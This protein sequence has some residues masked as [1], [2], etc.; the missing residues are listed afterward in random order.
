M[1]TEFNEIFKGIQ[2]AVSFLSK[3]EK[4]SLIAA[5]FIMLVTGFLTNLPAVILGK[6][7]DRVVS[8]NTIPFSIVI[9]YI[10]SIII[11]ILIREALTVIRKYLVEN[12]ATQTDKDISLQVIERLLK[13]DIQGFL[14]KQQIGSLH[15]RIFRSMQGLVKIIKLTFLDF[16]PI[17]F[18]AIAAIFIALYQ[19]PII[20]TVMILV[21]PMGLFLIIKQISSQKGIRISLLRGKEK[22]DGKVVEMLGGIETIRVLDTVAS[23]IK[24]I[25]TIAEDQRKIEIRHHIYMALFDAAKYLNEGFFYIIVILLSVYLASKGII[26]KGDILVYSILFVSITAPL[27]EIHRILDQAHESSIQVNDLYNLLQQP[28][29]KSFISHDHKKKLE[30][31]NAIEVKNLSFAFG[32]KEK[33]LKNIDLKIKTGESI[34]IVGSSGCGKTTLILIFLKLLHNYSGEIFLLSKSLDELS[35]EDI[36]EKIGYVSQKPFIFSGTIK[37]N[38]MYGLKSTIS[39]DLLENAA[40]KAQIYEEIINDLGGFNGKVTENGSNLSGGQR[41]RIAIARVML[42]KP[43]LIIF[44]EATSALDNTNEALIQQQIEKE[45]KGKT[46]I[47]I[48]HR[49]TTLKNCDRILVLDN[50]NIVQQGTYEDLANKKGLFQDFLNQK[51]TQ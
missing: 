50:G 46:M 31:D 8:F 9:P 36:S 51:H 7:T 3:R 40:K 30:D 34:G 16:T 13:T 6:L 38:I 22:V 18:S 15:G 20:A 33:L 23:E 1:T 39:E 25:E 11:I 41:Q 45:F 44:D 5:T 24:K 37:E 47:T 17:F 19:K 10:V 21:I 43:E 4:K 2:R 48:A 12:I 14:Y 35:R 29:D 42:K 28:L 49:L 32:A 27:R 26:S